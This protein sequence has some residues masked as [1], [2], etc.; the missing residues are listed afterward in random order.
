[1]V[2]AARV[3]G[4]ADGLLR[5]CN[6]SIAGVVNPGHRSASF[7]MR[8]A[9]TLQETLINERVRARVAFACEQGAVTAVQSFCTREPQRC[10]RPLLITTGGRAS[11]FNNLR[12]WHPRFPDPAL[13]RLQVEPLPVARRALS[14]KTWGTNANAF[15]DQCF[16]N[17]VG[18]MA[19]GYGD[20]GATAKDAGVGLRAPRRRARVET[21]SVCCTAGAGFPP[22][23]GAIGPYVSLLVGRAPTICAPD[24]ERGGNRVR[25]E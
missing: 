16:L 4:L 17:G 6:A 9:A 20:F 18:E 15:I 23:P 5:H 12:G 7:S 24:N 8:W 13:R 3:P 2:A 1:M 25:P 21:R 10:A 14:R 19:C 11:A 22:A